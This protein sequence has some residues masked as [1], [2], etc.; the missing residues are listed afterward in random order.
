VPSRYKDGKIGWRKISLRA[1]ETVYRW[2]FDFDGMAGRPKPTNPSGDIWGLVQSA[3]PYYTETTIPIDKL[4]LF[5]TTTERNNPEGRSLLRGAYYAYYC[6]KKLTELACVGA[7]R[8]LAGIPFARVP[9]HALASTASTEDQAMVAAVRKILETIRQNEQASILLPNLID[10]QT[11]QPMWSFELLKSSG[12]R[13]F[14][15]LQLVQHFELQ[16]ALALLMDA[17]LLGHEKIGT[18]SLATSKTDL[19]A[20]CMKGLLDI[21]ASVINRQAIPRLLKLNG[22]DVL[23]APTVRHTGVSEDNVM[24]L[25]NFIKTL[26]DAGVLVFPD[27]ILTQHLYQIAK[28][29]IEGRAQ[30]EDAIEAENN[31]TLDAADAAGQKEMEDGNDNPTEKGSDGG[32]NKPDDGDGTSK[33]SNE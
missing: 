7:E 31:A 11:Q 29:P 24:E 25:A 6:A 5:R 18:Q 3:P 30:M 8:D 19:L 15:V 16:I 10:P 33:P 17:I 23:K 32:K 4:L 1:Q 21:E 28:L 20:R 14:D 12:A 26:A 13:Q 22:M 9:A 27:E 2:V